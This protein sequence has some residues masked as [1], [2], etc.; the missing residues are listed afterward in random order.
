MRLNRQQIRRLILE[1]VESFTSPEAYT[2][3]KVK[4]DLDILEKLYV[5]WDSGQK[6][7]TQTE[8]GRDFFM[9]VRSL[10]VFIGGG[11]EQDVR[12]KEK[13]PNANELKSDFEALLK[14]ATDA[15]EGVT[16]TRDTYVH[17]ASNTRDV[18]GLRSSKR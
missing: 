9:F 8:F 7:K 10:L 18:D 6:T 1:E 4:N 12:G 13:A 17:R 5:D 2:D 15:R 11:V 14:S 16:Q 3:P